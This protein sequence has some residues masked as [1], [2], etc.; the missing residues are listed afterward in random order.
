MESK[1]AGWKESTG[2]LSQTE[3]FFLTLWP[4]FLLLFC[5]FFPVNENKNTYFAKLS[6]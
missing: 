5:S 1:I 3:N 2:I 4:Q 6:G